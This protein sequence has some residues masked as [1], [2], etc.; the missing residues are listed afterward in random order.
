MPTDAR[1]DAATPRAEGRCLCGGV[2]YRVAGPLGEVR[3]CHCAFCR[4]ASGT[5]FSAN[6]RVPADRFELLAGG[7]RLTAHEQ[8]PGVFRDSC[9]DCGAP[10]RGRLVAREPDFVRVRVGGLAA[11]VDVRVTAHVWVSRKCAWY[12]I[13]DALPRYAEAAGSETTT[14]RDPEPAAPAELTGQC[15]CGGVRIAIAGKVG[16]LVHCHCSQC[17][18][19][20]GSAFS[21]NADVRKKY[22]RWIAGRDLVREYESSPGKIRAF[23][24]H[25]GAPVYSRWD[26][27]P[28]MLRLRL[29]LVNEDPRRRA[30]AHFWVGSKAPWFEI[31]DALPQYEGGVPDV[32]V[33]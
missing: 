21:S 15:L 19:A 22:W 9:R 1:A 27:Q 6:A 20:T 11:D 8:L 33:A 24:T 30:L 4:R 13:T 16:P 5:A 10:V 25:C 29:G 28:D 7:D 17:R 12:A 18:I 32:P 31:T 3:Y 23:C 14:P 26:A 2:R